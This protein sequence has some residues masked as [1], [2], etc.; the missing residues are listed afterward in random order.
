MRADRL[1][2][3]LMLLQSRGKMKAG[4]LAEAL[5]VSERTVYRDIDA[6]SAAGVPVYG[7]P[8]PTG[9]FALLDTYQTRLTGLTDEELRVLFMLSI[10]QPLV[11]LGLSLELKQALLKLSA[12]LPHARRTLEDE[13]RLR[14]HLD[15]SVWKQHLEPL[16]HLQAVYQAVRRERRL[17]IRYQPIFNV[18]LEGWVDP[19][20]LVAK[21]GDWYMVCASAGK[22]V[23]HQV[24][25]LLE[26]RLGEGSFTR[27]P[28][29]DVAEFWGDWCARKA[30]ASQGY[31]VTVRV[32]PRLLPF[33]H[34][35]A[36]PFKPEQIKEAPVAGGMVLDLYFESLESA[37]KWLLP[38]GSG[39]EVLAPPA[40]RCSVIDFAEQILSVYAER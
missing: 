22:L 17:F 18:T 20:G 8:G 21:A 13:F 32:F 24:G 26:A 10:P 3:L 39:V 38:L 23:V 6:L 9:G 28:G 33:L 12:A 16:P 35:V 5:E 37:R 29:F 27:P 14:I 19:Y 25:E 30:Q 4:E 36:G 11:D 31:R 15:S 1:L 2:S 7:E 40:L 34:Q